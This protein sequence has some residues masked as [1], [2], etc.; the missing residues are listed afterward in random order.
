MPPKK[1]VGRKF[2]FVAEDEGGRLQSGDP[3][4][5]VSHC[6]RKR[7]NWPLQLPASLPSR[8]SA[9]RGTPP[10][11]PPLLKRL[12]SKS[13]SFKFNS[14]LKRRG[15]NKKTFNCSQCERTR[16]NGGNGSGR[17]PPPDDGGTS[18]SAPSSGSGSQR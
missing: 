1:K 14:V 15:E 17:F 16:R 9:S 18:S 4:P 7:E 2:S 6:G 11:N 5:I 10:R 12:Q 13:I 3:V 8:M